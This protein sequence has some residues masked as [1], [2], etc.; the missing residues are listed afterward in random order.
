MGAKD[1][2]HR[3]QFLTLYRGL[4]GVSPEE[5]ERTNLGSHWTVD[6]NV[7]VSFATGDYLGVTDESGEPNFDDPSPSAGTVIRAKVHKRHIVDPNSPEGEEWQD[8]GVTGPD[9][10]EQERTVRPNA[11]VHVEDLFHV[12]DEDT[13]R[14]APP[15]RRGWKA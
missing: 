13:R 10:Y 1:H 6:H 15:F 12:T 3:N 5:V 11:I 7:A 8:M 9:H 4:H 14:V 2:L